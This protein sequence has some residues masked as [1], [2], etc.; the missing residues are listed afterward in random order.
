MSTC[1]E[2]GS[3]LGSKKQSAKSSTAFSDVVYI[4]EEKRVTELSNN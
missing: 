1:N 2:S 4:P 3:V